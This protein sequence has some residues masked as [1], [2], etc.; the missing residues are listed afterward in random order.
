MEHLA[1]GRA[2]PGELSCMQCTQMTRRAGARIHP[3]PGLLERFAVEVRVSCW[4]IPAFP[5]PEGR[6]LFLVSVPTAV[7][8]EQVLTCCSLGPC[9]S[10]VTAVLS[11]VLQQLS[12][13]F[14][15]LLLSP[16]SGWSW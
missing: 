6:S 10:A 12:T 14:P 11:I 5:M 15:V 2:S 1:E 16:Q 9:Y 13:F 3:F 7:V 4:M 8:F